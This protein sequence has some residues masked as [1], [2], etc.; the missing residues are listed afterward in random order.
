MLLAH[1]PWPEI[2]AYLSQRT[3]ILL[4]IGATEQHGPF[5]PLGTDWICAEGVARAAGAR[6]GILVGPTLQVGMSLHHLGF[7]GSLSL[8]PSTMMAVLGDW[9]AA[10]FGHG[11][12]RLH[13]VN[14]HGGNIASVQAAFPEIYQRCPGLRG[15][16]SNWYALPAVDALLQERLG[17]AE[18]H[19]ATPGELSLAWHLRPESR[20]VTAPQ[21]PPAPDSGIYDAADFRRR[22]PDGRIGADQHRADPELGRE[23]LEVAVREVLVLHEGWLAEG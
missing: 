1:T 10:L 2:E 8:R 11:F 23:L 9:A 6:A 3:D 12:R 18:G 22:Y 15:R 4:P 14:G 7:P 19:H 13:F 21:P 16:L 5:G 20:R 17:D